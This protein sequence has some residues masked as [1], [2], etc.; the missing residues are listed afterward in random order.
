[1]KV[2]NAIRGADVTLTVIKGGDHGCRRR[3]NW[4]CC[5]KTAL[6]LAERADGV[7]V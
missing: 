7:T 4:R 1:M 5:V 6:R 3:G 2:F